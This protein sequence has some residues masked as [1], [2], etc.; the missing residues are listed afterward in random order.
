MTLRNQNG[1]ATAETKRRGMLE[2]AAV[3]GCRVSIT[4]RWDKASFD[5]VIMMRGCGK[6]QKD[7]K[8]KKLK[9]MLLE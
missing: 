4:R 6:D 5:G 3:L 2:R 1:I 8:G 9:C 7:K